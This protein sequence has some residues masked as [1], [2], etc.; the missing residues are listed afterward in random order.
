M[1]IFSVDNF[2]NICPIELNLYR[3][4]RAQQAHIPTKFDD[5]PINIKGVMIIRGRV[6][7][8]G[9]SVVDTFRP[10]CFFNP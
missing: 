4:V 10:K 8:T 5:Y 2:V 7:P 6:G 3:N 9:S 1:N